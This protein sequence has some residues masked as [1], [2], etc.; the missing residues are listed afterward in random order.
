M[1]H[2]VASMPAVP[3]QRKRPLTYDR[4]VLLS[5]LPAPGW[6]SVCFDATQGQ[7]HLSPVHA[8]A[9]GV[10]RR[11]DASTGRLVHT[12]WLGPEAEAWDLVGL[13]YHPCD[14]W[15]I[16]EEASNFCGLLTPTTT[17]ETFEAVSPWCHHG[18]VSAH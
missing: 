9:L 13:A 6:Q 4:Y 16:C 15:M 10:R 18:R 1:Q 2:D 5:L 14:G 12:P 7:H 8:L 17:L 11:Y 3:R